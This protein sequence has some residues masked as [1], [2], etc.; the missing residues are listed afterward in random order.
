MKPRIIHIYD[1]DSN[2]WFPP[3]G[4]D[5][6]FLAGWSGAIARQTAELTDRFEIENWRADPTIAT[7]ETRRVSG[8]TCRVFP[9]R[10]PH[11]LKIGP[12]EIWDGLG[13]ARARGPVVIHHSGIHHPRFYWLLRHFGDLPIAGQNHGDPRPFSWYNRR[14]PL[15]R[16][17]QLVAEAALFHRAA[18]F[19]YLRRAEAEYLGTV[20]PRVR[21]TFLTVGTEFDRPAPDE[22]RRRE[23]KARLGLD[24]DVPLVLYVGRFFRLKS[25]EWILAARRQLAGSRELTFC[26]VG[27][28]EQDDLFREVTSSGA[29]WRP[30]LPR[31]E[32]LLYYR[33]ADV[34][35]SPFLVYG[36]FD[37]AMMEA[38]SCG[39]PVVSRL[40]TELPAKDREQLGQAVTR[41]EDLGPAILGVVDRPNGFPRCQAVARRW[42]GWESIVSRLSRLYETCLERAAGETKRR[43][44]RVGAGRTT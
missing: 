10:D 5:E 3:A 19:L 22:V 25:V 17:A 7:P 12:R 16:I 42:F 9:A 27:G 18:G 21:R 24:P 28:S 34:Y 30:F 15:K 38:L 14:S 11:D 20:A 31:D 2:S 8:V 37:V 32:V 26:L 23:A 44:T 41:P 1:R 6:W 39:V 4:T 43:Q 13:E 29:T 36:G 40:L 33:A 35:L